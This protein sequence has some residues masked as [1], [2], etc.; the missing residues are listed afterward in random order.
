MSL[1]MMFGALL[2]LV[3]DVVF[4]LGISF[5]KYHFSCLALRSSIVDR[6]LRGM[7]SWCLWNQCPIVRKNPREEVLTCPFQHY[8]VP[9]WWLENPRE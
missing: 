5:M 1:M 2:M 7:S 8:L 4:S 9:F 3:P 6:M